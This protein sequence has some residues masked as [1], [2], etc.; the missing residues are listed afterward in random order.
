MSNRQ[1]VAVQFNPWD[2]RSYTYHHDGE[3][4]SVGD[5]VLVTTPRG[6]ST[7][8]VVTLVDQAPSFETKPIDGLAPPEPEADAPAAA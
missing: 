8:T 3:P 2:R 5:K 1:F 7:V 4:L 6:Q